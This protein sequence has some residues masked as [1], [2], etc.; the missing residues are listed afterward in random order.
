MIGTCDISYCT[1]LFT[2]VSLLLSRY[3]ITLHDLTQ[4]T[5]T[6]FKEVDVIVDE[7]LCCKA[8]GELLGAK[9][10]PA[11]EL[12]LPYIEKAV[13]A[14]CGGW[15]KITGGECTHAWKM[16]T[17]CQ[18]CYTFRNDDETGF[19]VY[20]ALNPNTAKWED[21]GNSPR[22]GF[23]GQWPMAWKDVV[24]IVVWLTVVST[25]V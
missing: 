17:G 18:E 16:L 23:H 11:G 25:V 15:D 24:S 7:R 9:P 20:G 14:L 13:A 5:K 22:D 21:L 1:F 4:R 10:S 8:D 2:L 12:W 3:T 6:G 19:R